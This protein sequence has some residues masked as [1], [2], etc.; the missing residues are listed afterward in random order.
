MDGPRDDCLRKRMSTMLGLSHLLEQ[1]A[2][3]T[4]RRVKSSR[5][6]ALRT[7]RPQLE[8]LE[9]RD[10]PSLLGQQLFPAD[11]PTNSVITNASVNTALNTYF[12]NNV[13]QNLHADWGQFDPTSG[14]PMYGIPYNV[15]HSAD[16]TNY[17]NVKVYIDAYPGDAD[18]SGVDPNGQYILTPLPKSGVVMIEGDNQNGPNA[19]RIGNNDSHLI[20]WDADTNKYYQ[21]WECARP[22]ENALGFGYGGSA[23]NVPNAWNAASGSVFN[24]AGDNFRTLGN[25]S[26]DVA[27]LAILSDLVRVDE[28][29][30]PA[31]LPAGVTAQQSIDHAIRF[32]LLNQ[33]IKP[34]YVYPA[35]HIGNETGQLPLAT[36][37]RLRDDNGGPIDTMIA[38]W[39]TTNPE[40][41]VVAKAMQQYGLILADGGSNMYISGASAA[42]GSNNSPMIDPTTGKALQWDMTNDILAKIQSIPSSDFDVVDLTPVVTGVVP[43]TGAVGTAVTIA[44]KN[45][46]GA[47]GNLHVKFGTLDAASFTIISDTLIIAVA[48]TGG[49]GTVD[50]TV[51]SGGMR[52][53]HNTN[54]NVFWGYGTSATGAADKFTYGQGKSWTSPVSGDWDTPGNWS[55]GTLPGMNDNVI[56]GANITVTH[57]MNLPDTIHSLT[58]GS[59]SS[60]VLSAG[61]ITD[62]TTLNPSGAG[63]SVVL[64]G[65]TLASECLRDRQ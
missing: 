9:P 29:V 19:A 14:N 37:L 39:Q 50:I 18:I 23:L 17:A 7:F 3:K 48:P 46:S 38:G 2:G 28:V 44:G 41:Y 26:G 63:A 54:M 15:V 35:S 60:L 43:A 53:D 55:G 34:Q 33:F 13:T 62:S 20:V 32:T 49:S 16:T 11:Y 36:R 31:H 51:V 1:L 8:E 27:G 22:T 64:S 61:T 40:S 52:L 47:A 56:I 58:L 57:G 5:P 59:G 10:L 65:G 45:F 4:R 25:D 24:M 6:Q 12:H 21:F 30:S 42:M